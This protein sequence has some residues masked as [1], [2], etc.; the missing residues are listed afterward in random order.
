MLKRPILVSEIR[1]TEFG[2][3]KLILYRLIHKKNKYVYKSFELR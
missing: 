2:I 1:M 3:P